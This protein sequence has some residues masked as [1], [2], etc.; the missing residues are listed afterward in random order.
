[1]KPSLATSASPRTAWHASS[2][3]CLA[4]LPGSVQ[5][6]CPRLGPRACP[7]SP[8]LP[9][10]SPMLSPGFTVGT[11]WCRSPL[12]RPALPLPCRAGQHGRHSRNRRPLDGGRLH[13]LLP[14]PGDG[15]DEPAA[16]HHPDPGD[17][18]FSAGPVLAEPLEAD[19][20]FGMAMIGLGHV[21]I[22]GRLPRRAL[23]WR[24]RKARSADR[25]P[26]RR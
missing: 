4:W 7:S 15:G 21:A 9:A 12:S 14:R 2:S 11:S 20:M 16:C 5:Q 23:D 3:V 6:C 26:A 17:R 22:G 10:R 18:S 25:S 1:M 19:Q 8:A 24:S 13:P